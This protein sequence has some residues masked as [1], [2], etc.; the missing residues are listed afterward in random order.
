MSMRDNE[1][2]VDRTPTVTATGND[3]TQRPRVTALLAVVCTAIFFD[4]LDLSI[5][6]IAL[7][8]IQAS[9]DL[10]VGTLPWV[11][12]AY[13]VTY[14][15]F[16]LLGGRMTDLL[17]GRRV[18]LAGLAIF[19]AASLACG[20]AGSATVLVV[21]RAVQGVGAALTV[22]AAVAILAAT[23][24]DD[25]ARARA[26]GIFAAAAASGF[27][28]GL[29]FGGLITS[30]LSW[31]WIFLAKVPAVALVLFVALRVVPATAGLDRRGGYDL[32][33]A[34]TVTGGA[35]L[36]TYGVTRA[37]SPG[38]SIVD[39]LVPVLAAAFLF[40]GFVL[41]E[42]RAQAPLLPPSVLRSRVRVAT[43]AAALTVLAAPFGLSFV[44]TIYLQDALHHSPWFT[45]LTLLPG[46]ALSGLVSRYLAP[47]LIDRIG[48]RPVYAGGLAIAAA[49]NAVLLALDEST[50]PWVVIVAGLVSLG[51]GMGL[52]YPA[53]T[54]GGVHDAHPDDQGAAAGLNN[55]A[56]QIGGAI[57]LAVV[58]TAVT[59]GLEGQSMAE[60]GA[61]TA[62][63]GA[64]YGA[65]A[66]VVLPLLGAAIVLFGLRRDTRARNS[67]SGKVVDGQP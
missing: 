19:G 44:V 29:V 20:L 18:F 48:L 40:A 17:G 63:T 25:R 54:L 21:A 50:A 16:L 56:L 28:A 7:P 12:A 65:V 6:Q 36:F 23:F 8:S 14:G 11:A 27:S 9:L 64:R 61:S 5:T 2:T 59:I 52:A 34:F 39:T 53:A 49:G 47:A 67:P 32:A 38:A 45:A 13:V 66:A 62:R 10:T 35:V 1:S 30:G 60:A 22:P 43:D 4:A 33:G 24:T 37:G 15:G 26:F 41:V 3:D 31:T 58:A 57:G 46:A 51:T 55:A 42:R